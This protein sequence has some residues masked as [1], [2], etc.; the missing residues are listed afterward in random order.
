[1]GLPI[2]VWP[3]GGGNFND[4]DDNNTAACTEQLG[5]GYVDC[6]EQ[7][8]NDGYDVGPDGLAC[9]VLF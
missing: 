4:T 8:E 3:P 2:I 5:L 6:T 7:A 9:C 1:M